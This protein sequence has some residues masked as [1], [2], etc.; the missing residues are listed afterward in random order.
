[1]RDALNKPSCNQS[2]V[3]HSV[4]SPLPRDI[5]F[6]CTPYV[7]LIALQPPHPHPTP[8]GRCSRPSKNFGKLP[9]GRSLPREHPAPEGQCG[10]G[11]TAAPGEAARKEAAAPPCTPG[12]GRARG[13]GGEASM[14]MPT[15]LRG[16][17]TAGLHLLCFFFLFFLFFFLSALALRF[18]PGWRE[19]VI[20]RPETR[21]QEMLNCSVKG[22]KKIK[23]R[24]RV[25][26]ERKAPVTPVPTSFWR[27][28][29]F[30]RREE[31]L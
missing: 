6:P 26:S 31:L 30:S 4:L 16:G 22:E 27:C 8:V 2:P 11:S 23:K 15:A 29:Y 17:Q 20:G 12:G 1:M 5:Y 28:N 21:F 10:A 14:P 24:V 25:E 9:G 19:R 3:L 13:L 7:P 18:L